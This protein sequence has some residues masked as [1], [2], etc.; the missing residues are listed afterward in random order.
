MVPLL[1]ALI[2]ALI[3]AVATVWF[4]HATSAMVNRWREPDA[5]PL[6]LLTGWI[7]FIGVGLDFARGPRAYLE[8]IRAQHG[9]TFVLRMFGINMLCVFSCT[10]LRSLYMAR[11]SDAS[12]TEATK[13]LL[14][15]KLPKEAMA[16]EDLRKFHHGLKRKL[17][18]AYAAN[19]NKVIDA[20]LAELGRG[21]PRRPSLPSCAARAHAVHQH[22]QAEPSSSS[23]TSSGWSIA[24]ASSAGCRP[25]RSSRGAA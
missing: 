16:D 2:A 15:L 8:R 21:A 17:L 6:P 24:W 3:I 22:P 23:R 7:P 13:G 11:E 20:S 25:W 14:G 9:D 12:F 18:D 10:G 4:K 19:V 5:S 1:T